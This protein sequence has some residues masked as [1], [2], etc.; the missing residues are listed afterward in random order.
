MP[1]RTAGSRLRA[2]ARLFPDL[3]TSPTFLRLRLA[4][5]ALFAFDGAVFGSWAARI[6]DVTAQVGAT[7]AT[8]GVALL[9]V[10]LGALATMQLTGVLAARFG[11]GLVAAVG[12]A[13]TCLVLPLPGLVTSLPQLCGALLLFGALTGLVNV[14][15]N[16]VGVAVEAMRPEKPLLTSLHAAFSFGGLAGAAAGGLASSLG[17]VEPH[18]LAVSAVGLAVTALAGPA[19]ASVGRRAPAS[20]AA[21]EPVDEPDTRGRKDGRRLV[22]LLGLI[23]GCTAFG[24]GAL[25][26]WGTLHLR[27]TLHAAPGL[28][29]AGYSGFSLAMACGRLSGGWLLRRLGETRLLTGGAVLAAAGMTGA[30]LTSSP[31]TALAGFLLV[32]LGLANLFPIAIARAGARSGSRGVALASTVG[33]TGLLGGPPAIGFLAEHAGLPVALAS[34][35]VLAL[36]AAGLALAVAEQPARITLPAT[37]EMPARL[38]RPMRAPLA[39]FAT[40]AA[41]DVERAPGPGVLATA[42]RAAVAVGSTGVGSVRRL[43]R[44]APLRVVRSA[45]A[46]FA[47]TARPAILRGAAAVQRAAATELPALTDDTTTPRPSRA[48]GAHIR[49]YPGLEFLAA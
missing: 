47:A 5:T 36:V 11:S 38:V 10:S 2:P 7:H 18:L 39:R 17:P 24:E 43:P 28:A 22:V 37:L 23:A 1:V 16:S 8:L 6:P 14:A 4:V 48:P 27:E 40:A 44:T 21:A 33:Y 34:V 19:L 15:V 29:A 30:L 13:G 20:E 41:R 35:P 9:C 46:R 45:H 3:R 42:A 31:I 49:P 25:T 12:V 26:D 32:G